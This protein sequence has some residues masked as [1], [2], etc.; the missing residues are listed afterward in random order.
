Q[1]HY[2]IWNPK[3]EVPLAKLG[4]SKNGSLDGQV[5]KFVKL[6]ETTSNKGEK[7]AE[8]L[9]ELITYELEKPKPDTTLPGSPAIKEE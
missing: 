6:I 9:T 7:T 3:S 8:V 2:W 5:H 4:I 1:R